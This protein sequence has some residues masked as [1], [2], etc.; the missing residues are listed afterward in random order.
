MSHQLKNA[1]E[2]KIICSSPQLAPTQLFCLWVCLSPGS[3]PLLPLSI[4]CHHVYCAQHYILALGGQT[5]L[6]LFFLHTEVK[7]KWDSKAS[8]KL[9]GPPGLTSA[10]LR[11]SFLFFV[12]ENPAE[13]SQSFFPSSFLNTNNPCRCNTHS[14]TIRT[15]GLAG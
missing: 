9:E 8:F 5:S 13:H 11:L 6:S 4:M 10:S 15:T 12:S 7:K 3:W 14:G 1:K 2:Q